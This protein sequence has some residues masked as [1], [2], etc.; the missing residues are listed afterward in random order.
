MAT[1]KVLIA[2]AKGEEQLAETLAKP[3]REIGYEV[4]H[5]GTVLVG[6][7]VVEEASK[8]LSLGGP[9]VLCGTVRALGTPWA[10]RVVSA[11]R[12]Y[13]GVRVFVVQMEEEADI[14][15]VSF[16]EVVARFW[17]DPAK[18]ILDLQAALR[19]Y[20]PSDEA[21]V[22]LQRGTTA[23]QHY[24]E[25]L[26]KSCDI[27]DVANLPAQDRHIA[28]R[29]LELRRLYVPLHAWVEAEIGE[30]S[31]EARWDAMEKRRIARMRGRSEEDRQAKGVINEYA[32][33]QDRQRA[34]IGE[35]LAHA[36]RLVVLGDPGAGKTTLT[37]W[38][39][40][41]Y[42]LRLNRD[43]D[44]S[45]LPDVMTLPDEE[46]LPIVIRCRNLDER[47]LSGSLD[48]ILCHTMRKA[49]LK[50][51]EVSAL[52][53]SLLERIDAGTALLILDGLDEITDPGSRARFCQQLEQIHQAFPQA[54]IIATSRIVG[55]REMGYQLGRSFEH[56]TL[57][58]LDHEEKD[59][60]AR[61]WCALT[62]RPERRAD[63]EEELIHD[64]HSSDRIERLTGNP[65][66]LT[67]MALVKRNVGKLPS[68][69]AD[70]YDE[71]V[72]VLLNWRSEVDKPLDAHEAVPQLAYLAH[73]MCDR[74]VQQLRRDEVLE[75]LAQM[76]R[77]YPNL[78]LIH[79]QPPEAFLSQTEARTGILLEAGHTHYLGTTV[80][81]YEFR[82]LTFQEYL[83]ALA[84]VNGYFS[85]RDPKLPLAGHVAPLA[86]QTAEIAFTE[87]G[88]KEVAVV[89]IWR[90][91]LRLCTDICHF[92]DVDGILNAIL[93]PRESEPVAT[94]R[95]R[96]I[97]AMLCL[98]DEP[99][100]SDSVV[101]QILDAFVRQVKEDD[102]IGRVNTAADVA[103]IQVA[104]TRWGNWLQVSLVEEFFCRD[105][106]SRR[107]VGGLCGMVSIVNTPKGPDATCKW[108]SQQL[109]QLR[110]GTEQEATKIAL[111]IMELAYEEKMDAIPEL[112][113]IL[114]DRLSGS[115]PMAMA[116]AWALGWLNGGRPVRYHHPIWSPTM[117]H[118]E[119]ILAI[120]RNL[121]TES[122]TIHYLSWILANERI[123]AAVE[124]LVARLVDTDDSVRSAAANALGYI[125]SERAVE[126][127]I[128]RLADTDA[129]VR[130]AAAKALGNIES[131]RA[132]EPLIARL[133]D[134]DAS[135][136]SAAAK[137]LGN[138]ESERAVEPLVARLADTDAS[139][140][141]AAAK[142]LGNIES[143]RAVEP[144]LA[145]LED[146]EA[147]VR[148]AAANALGNIESERAVEP[149]VAR[150][151]DTDASV[152]SA[153]AKALGNIESERA[154]EPLLTRLEDADASVRSSAAEGLGN[155][156][157]ERVV[158]PLLAKLEDTEV[159]VRMAVV[160]AL[161][162]IR[163]EQTVGSLLA[164]LGDPEVS[165]RNAVARA[166]GNI[167]SEQAVEPLLARLEDPE[168]SM[169]STAAFA[170]GYIRN[171]QAVEPLLARLDDTDASVRSAA[172]YAL[173][174][175]GNERAVEPLLA[176]LNNTEASVRIAAAYALGYIGNERA[177]EPLLARLDDTE[178]SV[179]SAT[180][181]A[182][183]YIGNEQAVEPL[184][185]RLDDTEASVRFATTYAL[186]FIKDE[187]SVELLEARLRDAAASVRSAAA[188]ALGNIG[189]ERVVD[190]LM[191]GMRDPMASVRRAVAMA[192]GNIGGLRA[193]DLLVTH[194]GDA[195][196]SVRCA[197]IEALG[198]IGC[199]RVIEPLMAQLVHG[200]ASVRRAAAAS[201]GN[202]GIER[203]VEPLLARLG[204]SEF[205]VRSAIAQA[206]A[207]TGSQQTVEP[208]VA[209]L[210]DPEAS[211]RRAAAYALGKIYRDLEDYD[212]SIAAYK[213]A[214][215]L[216][217][218]SAYTHYNLG[219][220]YQ[221]HRLVEKALSEY[222]ISVR[223][224][225]NNAAIHITLA[226]VLKKLGREGEAL[227]HIR[228]ASK[229]IAMENNYNYACF[230][231]VIGNKEVALA[232]LKIALQRTPRLRKWARRDPD[233]DWIR[234]D[235][236]FRA[237]VK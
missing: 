181:Y 36:R 63:A 23:E 236:R 199:E 40:T 102:G 135:V 229:K 79:R 6:E 213:H 9:V 219:H 175:I 95:A 165:V 176:Q 20:Y 83:T 230:E 171:V 70:L 65:M 75:L 207:N 208:L 77:E 10:R 170:L 99:N 60:F 200:E 190:S 92:D 174:N 226:G 156:R 178:A 94:A 22:R 180:A 144:L 121:T 166:L 44:W 186:G 71:A 50:E 126:P 139:V 227:E 206:L 91:V 140:R 103:A 232:Q 108:L 234:N 184:L 151:A 12:H 109:I 56:V 43:P 101:H 84:L 82:H 222:H 137:A 1:W 231:F 169:R 110:E 111:T 86:G 5:Q 104:G 123:V 19:R 173:G 114:L 11:A 197:A 189:C 21:G 192:L 217:P 143:E 98:V 15:A 90:E 183:G 233:L 161:G 153:A 72:Q 62:E 202:I 212:K 49:E 96:A 149:L 13:S 42:L 188:G 59:D 2:H 136:R 201:L 196:A 47:C 158:E 147:D 89:E 154:V 187:R 31:D 68:R 64:I 204:D 235:P 145:R 58:D 141:S 127:L 160:R 132:V 107:Y 163:S 116:S 48:D 93:V 3:L 34:P 221:L 220:V 17:Q 225:P 211:V 55:Y 152:R 53:E 33:R 87:K 61:R 35:R 115:G 237:L 215:L 46:W 16:D 118:I 128:A 159:S 129:S 119:R 41:A 179:R 122:T 54:P 78:H 26:L 117:V 224:E 4:A 205:S 216:D 100:A 18:A 177:V 105:T 52:Q 69:R 73:A 30:E 138:I 67:T 164:R 88:K 155:I 74:G 210:D 120:I 8:T 106:K 113:D 25:L 223:L 51:A 185:A 167:R 124:P 37:R 182:L 39:A 7:S 172:A 195:V 66:L 80:P 168:A 112:A 45:N 125:E 133:A 191:S 142:A 209:R 130:S 85:G 198:N 14:E 97:M 214:C 150:L 131:E 218:Q 24:R 32:P 76:R 193:V 134:T 27:I 157:N 146:G 228:K 57:A 162:M 203:V 194:L 148:R 29:Q 38:I 81:V 28:H